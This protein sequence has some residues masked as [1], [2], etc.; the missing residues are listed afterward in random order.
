MTVTN[1]ETNPR[2][3]VGSFETPVYSL[4]VLHDNQTWEQPSFRIISAD[5]LSESTIRM[6][7]EGYFGGFISYSLQVDDDRDPDSVTTIHWPDVQT[8]R[9]LTKGAG[10][11]SQNQ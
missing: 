9:R 10:R 6:I 4:F 8:I 2:L 3:A 11:H 1:N 7:A 5:R